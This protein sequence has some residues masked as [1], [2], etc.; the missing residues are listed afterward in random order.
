MTEK[1]LVKTSCGIC[2]RGC[3]VVVKLEDGQPVAITGDFEHPRSHGAICAKGRA[4]LEFLSHPDRLKYPLKRAGERGE[5]KW[6]RISWDE[7]LGQ[8][9]EAWTR[10]KDFYGAES[11]VL[12]MGS[13]KGI[14]RASLQRLAHAF[15]TPNIVTPANVCF[16]PSSFA[17]T[18]TYG[19]YSVA[20]LEHPP[21]S[22]L[23]WGYNPAQTDIIEYEKA[24]KA[25]EKGAKVA[26]IDPM[27]IEL[28]EQA[29]LWIQPRPS[30]D[31]AL[32]LAMMNVIINEELYD[33]E[34]VEKWTNGFDKLKEHVQEYTPEKV[35][36]I[37]WVDAGKIREVARFYA[38]NKPACILWGNALEHNVNSFQAAR[39]LTLLRA[40]T[41]N[42]GV[43]GGEL[44]HDDLPPLT[45]MYD[46]KW[47]LYFEVPPDVHEMGILDIN[48]LLPI[49][50]SPPELVIKAILEEDP[51]PVR[52]LYMQAANPLMGYPN[53]RQT[54][55][56]LQKLDFFS[57]ADLFMTPTAS[58]ADI[59]L[60]AA[61]YLEYD[62]I[63]THVTFAAAQVQEKIA[64]VGE[65][66]SD[67][68]IANELAKKLGLRHHFWENEEAMLDEILEPSNL[69]YQQFKAQ[70]GIPP[71]RP[72]YLKD[73]E[74]GKGFP[75]Q[76]GKVE[77]FSEF[78]ARWDF[79]PLPV[80]YESPETPLSEPDLTREYPLVLT[81][82][83]LEYYRH[84]EGRQIPSLRGKHPDPLADIHP[85]TAGKLDI[86]DSDWVYIETRRGRIKQ[87]AHI[88]DGVDPRVVFIEY[89]WWFPEKGP[90]GLFAWIE[91]NANALTSNQPP[92]NREM[93]SSNL[94]GLLCKVYKS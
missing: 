34:F 28:V 85:E 69:T 45:R 9:A 36:G 11:V 54:L 23:V 16:L 47:L 2:Y 82:R 64:Q 51:Y 22:I 35:A 89:D 46:K 33:R 24:L 56:A 44:E 80:Y 73:Y 74:E 62:S 66:W 19:Y 71:T 90:E 58:M 83:K 7:A 81:S 20:D 60:P 94:R 75:T 88:T 87:R 41:G 49:I 15:G 68:R 55:Q 4:S 86:K 12:L 31:L 92:L 77:L 63:V 59:V 50:I 70:Q 43:P 27:R 32:A 26:V 72:L 1:R 38:Q 61:T 13:Y 5:G 79:D 40:I 17:S 93:A 6:Q 57:V 76:S 29:E 52:V 78:V 10:S 8:I 84:S 14:Q 30:S 25:V 67:L 91:S 48:K 21:A 3:P 42:L 53:T 37:T 18:V 65:A 39:A